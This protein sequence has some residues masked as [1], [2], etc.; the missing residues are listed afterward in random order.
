MLFK[1][2]NSFTS[3]QRLYILLFV[4]L[5]VV[6]LLIFFGGKDDSSETNE[7]SH[8]EEV[9]TTIA[10]PAEESN[11]I[12][13]SEIRA[14][15]TKNIV[16]V[17]YVKAV[18]EAKIINYVTAVEEAKIVEYV[19]A[20]EHAKWHEEQNRLARERAEAA[21]NTETQ[22]ASS[23]INTTSSVDWEAIRRCECPSGWHCNTGNGYYGGLQFDITTW[24]SVGGT[25]YPHEYSRAEQINKAEILHSRRGLSPWPTCGKYG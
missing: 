3:R 13:I 2:F 7:V 25:G 11:G 17:K 4:F 9:V 20:V 19:K 23:Q 22:V 10:E 21:Q 12:D 6:L 1:R 16:L 14:L 24:Q 5:V 18:E 8:S 15:D